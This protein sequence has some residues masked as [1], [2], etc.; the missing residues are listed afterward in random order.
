MCKITL[1]GA[2]SV[3]VA[4][5]WLVTVVSRDIF[6]SCT[7]TLIINTKINIYTAH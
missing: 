5:T 7:H 4:T 1:H 3:A 6:H 2:T